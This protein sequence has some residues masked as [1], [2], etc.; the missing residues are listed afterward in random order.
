MKNILKA[1]LIMLV[2]TFLIT[3]GTMLTTQNVVVTLIIVA[4]FVVTSIAH[5]YVYHK[6]EKLLRELKN[7]SEE[8]NRILS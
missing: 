1:C 4:L 8:L 5:G 7:E 2:M 3:F 6:A